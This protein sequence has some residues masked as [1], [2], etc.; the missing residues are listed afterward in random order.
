MT[1][2]SFG[3]VRNVCSVNADNVLTWIYEVQYTL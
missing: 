2:Q 3:L 1:E